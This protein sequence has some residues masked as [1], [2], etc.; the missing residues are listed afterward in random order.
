VLNLP[1]GV[2]PEVVE[3]KIS[4]LLA[5]KVKQFSSDKPS[6]PTTYFRNSCPGEN[7][8]LIKRLSLFLHFCPTTL[9][10]KLLSFSFSSCIPAKD[11]SQ[12]FIA[13][14]VTHNSQIANLL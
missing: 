5:S 4:C 3:G 12:F 10:Q 13:K 8:H 11:H 1:G 6:S 2:F 14:H 7:L 9:P